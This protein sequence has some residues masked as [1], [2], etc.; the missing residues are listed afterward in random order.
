MTFGYVVEPEVLLKTGKVNFGPLLLGDKS[1]AVVNLINQEHLPF[2]F[3]LNKE[4]IRG[5]PD[6]GDSL[7]V[8]H[9]SGTV[10]PQFQIPLE[11]LFKLK[12]KMS[13]N[14]NF[15]SIIV[16]PYLGDIY[17]NPIFL[18]KFFE[19]LY[20]IPYPY[21]NEWKWLN[22][23]PK[24]IKNIWISLH[25]SIYNLI[26]WLTWLMAPKRKLKQTSNYKEKWKDSSYQ[27][28]IIINKKTEDILT[29][30]ITVLTDMLDII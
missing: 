16:S 9:L 17:E 23:L 14:D 28:Q 11:V 3:N 13:Y 1:K 12:Y 4:S 18:I 10:P 5:N 6:Y 15:C 8:T 29:S 21:N 26:I 25:R 2:A 20:P 19:Y 22:N 30:I 27:A 24:N 7:A